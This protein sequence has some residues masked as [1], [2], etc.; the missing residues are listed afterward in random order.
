MECR[1]YDPV[2]DREGLWACKRAFELGLGAGTGNDAKTEAYE[3]KLS[4]RYRERYLAWVDRC[5]A[6][7][8]GCVTVA[9][10]EG[11][12]GYVFVLPEGLSLIWDSAVINELYVDPDHRGSGVADDLMEAAYAV[13]REQELPLDRVV[14]DV[15]RA[16]E[17]AQ[18]FYARHGFEHWGEMVA[19]EL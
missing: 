8:P 19:R 9:F 3:G 5:V 18:A 13:A 10:E 1:P 16:N 2:R 7:D 15:D 4:E 14:L 12:V 6:D 11:V 17:R